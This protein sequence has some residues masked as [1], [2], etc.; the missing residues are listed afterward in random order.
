[1]YGRPVSLT[2][3][4]QEKFKTPIGAILTI[5]VMSVLLG[6]TISSSLNL[7]DMRNPILSSYYEDSFY[8]IHRDLDKSEILN[9]GSMF[10]FALG[11]YPVSSSIG[12]FVVKQLYTNRKD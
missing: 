7:A 1:M 8:K 6:F 9:P 5:M 2:F 12:R 11:Q 3:H 4:G 10:F